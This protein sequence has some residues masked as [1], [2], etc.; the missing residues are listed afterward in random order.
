MSFSKS[1]TKLFVSF[2]LLLIFAASAPGATDDLLEQFEKPGDAGFSATKLEEARLFYLSHQD[3]AGGG[4]VVIYKGKILVQWGQYTQRI[5]MHSARKSLLSALYGIHVDEGNIDMQ[6]TLAEL[7]IDDSPPLTGAEKTARVIQLIKARSGVYHEAAAETQEMRD[8]RPERGSHA[9][10]TFW[11]YNN[12]D[13]NAL[14]TIFIQETG[15]DIFEEFKARIADPIGM[16]DFRVEDCQYNYEYQYSIHPQYAFRMSARDRARFG[17]LFL[18]NGKWGDQQL[19]PEA[20]VQVSTAFHSDAGSEIPGAGYGYM[21][22]VLPK[23]VWAPFGLTEFVKYDSYLAAGYHGQDIFVIPGA[24]MVVAFAVDS[25]RGMDLTMEV[26]VTLVEMILGAKEFEINDLE[27]LLARIKPGSAERGGKV[28]L[29]ARIRNGGRDTSTPAKVD[30][31]LS[32][33]TALSKK[34]ILIGS[35]D[36][37]SI[38]PGLTKTVRAKLVLPVK[39]KTG[40][41]YVIADADSANA[42]YDPYPGNNSVAGKKKITIKKS[43]K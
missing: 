10:G 30:F 31:Y 33:D 19:V 42:N 34:D 14:G 28:K 2:F 5:R 21:W 9:P 1:A 24:D 35:A 17:L 8:A 22:W 29:S 15:K 32:R 41:Y 36:L 11:Y 13:F 39:L 18:Q 43:K 26:G 7:G 6:A 3:T 23:E 40:N 37:A 12:W 38:G 20:W 27:G 16:Q 25:D 4:L